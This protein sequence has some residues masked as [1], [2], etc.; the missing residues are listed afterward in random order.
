VTGDR[1]DDPD[2]RPWH[3]RTST[4]VG[5]SVAGLA[6]IGILFLLISYIARDVN[7]PDQAPQ[8]YL[9]EPS[10]SSRVTSS[11]SSTTTTT[12]TVTSTSPPVTTDINPGDET[13][14][15]SSDTTSTIPPTTR[16]T[17]TTDD[18]GASTSRS[19]PRLNETRTLYPRP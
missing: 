6:V 3:E 8:Y 15:S 12:E 2:G 17:T 7:A 4:V 9:D 14:T 5:A 19:R 1:D 11:S 18:G 13:T 10:G 16:R